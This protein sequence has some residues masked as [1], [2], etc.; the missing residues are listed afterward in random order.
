[1][2]WDQGCNHG[3]R[4]AWRSSQVPLGA[5]WRSGQ[6]LE[7]RT[8]REAA[9]KA[10]QNKEFDLLR[11]LPALTLEIL[12]TRTSATAVPSPLRAD[13]PSPLAFALNPAKVGTCLSSTQP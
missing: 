11:V 10:P 2:S 3:G 8:A 1:M 12:T 13:A 5:P 6:L 7:A 4:A 9:G